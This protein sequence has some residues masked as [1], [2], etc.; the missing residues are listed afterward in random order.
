[1]LHTSLVPL[2][3]ASMLIHL[4]LRNLSA[5]LSA[6]PPCT[7]PNCSATALSSRLLVQFSA[8]LSFAKKVRDAC[9][10]RQT[11]CMR[12][13]RV[14]AGS[15]LFSRAGLGRRAYIVAPSLFLPKGQVCAFGALYREAANSQRFVALFSLHGLPTGR[16]EWRI[17]NSAKS[18]GLR[19]AELYADG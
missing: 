3:L 16:D 12:A 1:M 8:C 13:C 7:I 17:R 15:A 11:I 10:V 4:P 2:W 5:C 6:N 9:C 14:V 19:W 18:S